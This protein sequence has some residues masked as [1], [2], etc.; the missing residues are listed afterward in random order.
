MKYSI[1]IITLIAAQLLN[2]GE[3]VLLEDKFNR[4]MDG[5]AIGNAWVTN[6]GEDSK[7]LLKANAAFFDPTD[8]ENEPR[9]EHKFD[10][11]ESGKFTVAFDFDWIR[12]FESDWAFYMQ[13]GHSKK[14]PKKMDFETSSSDGIAVNLVWGGGA[15][16]DMDG[17]I[18]VFGYAKGGKVTLKTKINDNDEKDTIIKK[19]TIIITVDMD[20]S[21]FSVMLDG[22]EYKDM[23]FDN[24]LP[25]DSIRF[26]ADKCNPDN[27]SK[28]SIDNVK[29]T[30]K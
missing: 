5:D 20:K 15:A 23:P 9:M 12:D 18:G 27:F 6:P 2:A 17:E 13:L 10:L 11:Q 26:I 28:R 4:G 14:M 25:I 21:M 7:M 30:K 3:K 19:K 16:I 22:K 29:I 24:K 1:L 8:Q